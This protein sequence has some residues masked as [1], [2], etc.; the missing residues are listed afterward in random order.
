MDWW[1]N[2]V[3][4]VF[5]P[6]SLIGMTLWLLPSFI[7]H[8]WWFLVIVLL[9]FVGIGLYRHAWTPYFWWGLIAVFAV[10]L[11]GTIFKFKNFPNG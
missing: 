10:A 9:P 3:F 8:H 11:L 4:S 2:I 6:Y 5:A 1:G 7:K